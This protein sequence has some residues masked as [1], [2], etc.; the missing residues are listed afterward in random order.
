MS[1][2]RRGP[3][4]ERISEV[5][6]AAIARGEYADGRL[7]PEGVLAEQLGV[8]RGTIRVALQTLVAEG[9]VSR[10]PR[11]GTTINRHAMRSTMQLNRLNS[12]ASLVEHAGYRPAIRTGAPV[13][14]ELTPEQAA[15]LRADP[16]DPAW[17]IRRVVLADGLPVISAVD[18]VPH[19]VVAD[20]AENLTQPDSLLEFLRLNGDTVV[21]YSASS[22]VP[23]V[24]DGAEP[25]GLD[26]PTG[27]PYIQL[28]EVFHTRQ[29]EPVAISIVSVVDSAIRLTML[30]QAR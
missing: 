13:V 16:A 8:S 24:A 7:P 2:G 9:I 30:R 6:L 12:F 15:T 26:L 4:P 3:L 5:L 17:T 1:S 18:V 11:L 25:K 29:D 21:G 10:R 22:F 19:R 14:S 20:H 28:H 23:C 27:T